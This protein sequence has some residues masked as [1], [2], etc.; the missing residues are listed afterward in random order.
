MLDG[1]EPRFLILKIGQATTHNLFMFGYIGK[2]PYRLKRM[3]LRD[4]DPGHDSECY[5]VAMQIA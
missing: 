1:V 2:V 3:A 5:D 4:T